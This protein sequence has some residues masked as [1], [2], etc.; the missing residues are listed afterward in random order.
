MGFLAFHH[1][2]SLVCYSLRGSCV[3]TAPNFVGSL[4]SARQWLHCIYTSTETRWS[5]GPGSGFVSFHYNSLARWSL[6]DFRGSSMLSI[7][8]SLVPARVS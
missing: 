4:L 3:L 8:V 1:S 7:A 2:E 6:P 5:V